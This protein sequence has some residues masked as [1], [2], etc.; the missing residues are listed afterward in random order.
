MNF[1]DG[2]N[3]LIYEYFSLCVTFLLNW[4]IHGAFL[5]GFFGAFSLVCSAEKRQNR[6]LIARSAIFF[7]VFILFLPWWL[8][9]VDAWLLNGS[10]QEFPIRF[11]WVFFHAFCLLAG[12]AVWL[13]LVRHLLPSIN[14]FFH[15]MTRRSALERNQRTDVRDIKKH[16]P[17]AKSDYNPERWLSAN[18]QKKGLFI[19]LCERGKPVYISYSQ[20]RSSHLQ[21]VGTS[22]CGK[23][24]ATG[25]LLSQALSAGEAV[26]VF[27]PKN[28][29]W[30]PHVLRDAAQKEGV[31]FFL[32]DL[33]NNVPQLDLLAGATDFEVEEM[34][35]SG[36]SLGDS[37][38]I[39]DHYRLKDRAAIRAVS[40][41]VN[42][43]SRSV[44]EL[45]CSELAASYEKECE[46]AVFKLRELALCRALS[47][48]GG[49]NM[50]SVVNEGGCIYIIGSMDNSRVLMAQ[51]ML[52]VRL[53]QIVKK[54]DRI[55]ETPRQVCAFL[56]ELKY[57]LSKKTL[58]GLG[59]ARDK[60]LHFVM[61]HQSLADL[62]DGP[63]DL[64]PDAVVGAIV[65]NCAIRIAY[66]VQN[67][68]T[69]LW[70]AKMSGEILVD[71]ETRKIEKNIGGAEMLSHDRVIRQ[72]TRH[73][74]DINMLLNLPERTAVIFGAGP[75]QFGHICPIIVPKKPLEVFSAPEQQREKVT[76]RRVEG[77]S[78]SINTLYN[79]YRH[80]DF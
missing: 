18:P 54:R 2:S 27:D 34:L 47:G 64:N 39:A 7:T 14:S 69:A 4:T 78:E 75:P 51:K 66:R 6:S 52:L 19:G 36:F 15:R 73:L 22:G 53:L 13:F 49:L 65:E 25:V 70:L 61:A 57:L 10:E 50:A 76:E 40:Q 20:W 37:G 33:G 55:S 48:V 45:A 5:S 9:K 62:R 59:A 72:S 77:D 42:T 26:F 60:G 79:D 56:D 21:I 11:V 1:F 35:C 71:D 28:D 38:D 80:V 29:E 46:G 16:L 58:E 43:G 74:V 68:D 8:P 17:Q 24:V 67:P 12:C 3:S 23:G 30:A 41:L 44:E 32:I 63:K 31:P